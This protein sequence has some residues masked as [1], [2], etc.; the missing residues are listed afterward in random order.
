M[1][2]TVKAY[3]TKTGQEQPEIRRFGIDADVP[4]NYSYLIGKIHTVFPG[5]ANKKYTLGWRDGENDLIIF[6]SDDELTEALGYVSDGVFKIYIDEKQ[7]EPCGP[8]P[9]F[10]EESRCRRGGGRAGLHRHVVCDGCQG[11]VV[12]VRY[13][14]EVCPDYD[15]CEGCKT[16][17]IHSEHSFKAIDKPVRWGGRCGFGGE[18]QG[19]N[20]TGF[21]CHFP[22]FAFPNHPQPPTGGCFPNHPPPPPGGC[23]PGA[24]PMFP[25]APHMFG[26]MPED[27]IRA[28]RRAWRHWMHETFKEDKKQRKAEKRSKKEEKKQEKKDKKKKSSDE[29]KLLGAA[30]MDDDNEKK[31]EEDT[32]SS[33]SS[34]SSDEEVENG[35][36]TEAYLK[37]VGHSVAA[38]LDPLGIQVEVDVEHHGQRRRCHKPG[39]AWGAWGPWGGA[40]G[41]AHFGGPGPWGMGFGR[42][43]GG[44]S[45]R[46]RGAWPAYPFPH[47]AEQGGQQAGE[48]KTNEQKATQS[49]AQVNMET[50]E[51]RNTEPSAPSATKKDVENGEVEKSASPDAAGWTFV[52]SSSAASSENDVE[53]A[54]VGV[55]NLHVSTASSAATATA[56]S[57]GA[58][59]ADPPNPAVEEAMASLKAMGFTDNGGWL[60]AL[61]IAHSGDVNTVLDYLHA[62]SKK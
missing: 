19:P 8:P 40:R 57:E 51:C 24:P 25:G 35:S 61:V 62:G 39:G 48:T 5:L 4:T 33:S 13:K 45:F 10:Q 36:P 1:S 27:V 53:G 32:T 29:E 18:M 54:T 22:P 55:E 3:L 21:Q 20:A 59:T 42:Q 60:K 46:G 31:K 11:P 7:D 58:A 23:M 44:C 28:Q 49:E 43:R 38:M 37:K 14:C 16:K 52:A 50:G 56:S 41:G 6:S 17:G 30:T 34:S 9:P 12:G 47:C 26:D 15:L 2:L